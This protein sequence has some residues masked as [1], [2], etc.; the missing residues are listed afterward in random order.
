MNKPV[1]FVTGLGKDILRAENLMALYNAYDGDKDICYIGNQMYQK[2][3]RDGKYGLIVID[4]FPTEHYA[5]TILLWH[6]IQGGKYIGL[7]EK[8]T[9]YKPEYAQYIDYVI[10]A[11]S[12]YGREMWHQCTG[13]PM[14]KILDYGMPRTDRYKGKKKGDGHTAL[15]EKKAYLYAPTFRAWGEPDLPQ[16]DWDW[17]DDQLTDDELFIVKPHPQ[18]HTLTYHDRYK[19]IIEADRMEPT[20]NYLYDADVI[21]TDYSSIIFDGYLLGKPAVLYERDPAYR[22]KR[23]VYLYYPNEYCSYFAD[24]EFWLLNHMRAAYDLGIGRAEKKCIRNIADACDG[25]SC[26][27]I[28]ELIKE[29]I[30][31]G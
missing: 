29:M 5:P 8:T 17:L 24:N 7:D 23:G 10:A 11:G 28:C 26:E 12:G 1:L 14:D 2:D 6:S 20:V 21:I 31:N 3:A 9:Y 16:I 18:S 15:A 13:V 25:H 27:R 19:H 22:D 4:I 30:D